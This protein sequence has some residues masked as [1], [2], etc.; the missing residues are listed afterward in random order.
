MATVES[1]PAPPSAALSALRRTPLKKMSSAPANP[2]RTELTITEL[3]LSTK[4]STISST[5]SSGA[6]GSPPTAKATIAT[7]TKPTPVSGVHQSLLITSPFVCPPPS[8]G[9]GA[10]L[11]VPRDVR[12]EPVGEGDHALV[13]QLPAPQP[14]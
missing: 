7:T 6:G 1:T 14:T 3:S 2:T 9:A 12:H 8:W 11:T 10:S 13:L 5:G 4:K